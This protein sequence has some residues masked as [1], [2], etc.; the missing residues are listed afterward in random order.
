M[1][2]ATLGLNRHIV[3]AHADVRRAKELGSVSWAITTN[4]VPYAPHNE[5]ESLI[6]IA[7]RALNSS[8]K[9]FLYAVVSLLAWLR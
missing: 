7:L 5:H 2:V 9:H 8:D 1:S 6:G 4:Q 3:A